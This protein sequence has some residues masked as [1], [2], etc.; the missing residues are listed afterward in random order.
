MSE[1]YWN[2]ETAARR[3]GRSVETIRKWI[4]TGRLVPALRDS[5]GWWFDRSAIEAEI[6]AAEESLT[7]EARRTLE[8]TFGYFLARFGGGRRITGRALRTWFTE[9]AEQEVAIANAPTPEQVDRILD[10]SYASMLAET[11]SGGDY[12]DRLADTKRRR[13]NALKSAAARKRIAAERREKLAKQGA[14]KKRG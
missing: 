1:R 12:A 7:E 5:E 2:T 9:R 11:N 10:E 8:R 14:R 3:L 4:K 13:A 6:R